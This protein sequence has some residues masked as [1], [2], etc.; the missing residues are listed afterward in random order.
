MIGFLNKS[1]LAQSSSLHRQ[2][3]EHRVRTRYLGISGGLCRGQTW[4]SVFEEIDGEVKHPESRGYTQAVDPTV[5]ETL[6]RE[7]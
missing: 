5:A 4:F 2:L 6:R 1:V 7:K 3:S